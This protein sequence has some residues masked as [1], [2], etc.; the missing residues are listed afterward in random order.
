MP[1]VNPLIR[2]GAALVGFPKEK[3]LDRYVSMRADESKKCKDLAKRVFYHI[4]QF[5]LTLVGCSDKQIIK[6]SAK[7]LVC[8]I[9]KTFTLGFKL[10]REMMNAIKKQTDKGVTMILKALVTMNNLPIPLSTPAVEA[11]VV[12]A[13]EANKQFMQGNLQPTV[14]FLEK[15]SQASPEIA[16]FK[17]EKLLGF[18]KNANVNFG[19][20]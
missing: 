16:A 20:S 2:I 17:I 13:K 10:P 3:Q 6:R 12:R 9:V 4:A 7:T 8:K 18:F 5:F 19:I 14:D 15:L 1:T 11:L